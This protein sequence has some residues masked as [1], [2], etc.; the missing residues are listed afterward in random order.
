MAQFIAKKLNISAHEFPRVSFLW[1][2]RFL[3]QFGFIFAWTIITAMFVS[4]FGVDNILY[5]LLID[6]ALLFLGGF[7]IKYLFLKTPTNKFLLGAIAGTMLSLGFGMYFNGYTEVC[8]LSLLIAKDFFFAQLGLG[9]L[10]KNESLLSPTEAQKVMPVIESSITIGTI[11]A[12]ALFLLLLQYFPVG[13]LLFVWLITLGLMFIM[14]ARADKSLGEV[15]HLYQEETCSLEQ[16]QFD[17]MQAQGVPFIKLLTLFIF[18]QGAL[19]SV[20]E[21]QFLKSVDEHTAHETHIEETLPATSLEASMIKDTKHKITEVGVEVKETISHVSNKIFVHKTLAHDLGF[22][23]LVFGLLALVVQLSLTTRILKRWGIIRTI[24]GYFSGFLAIIATFAGGGASMNFVRG[25]QHGF[26]SIL[27]VPYH[28]SFYSMMSH[29]REKVR[30]FLEGFVK[31]IGAMFGITLILGLQPYYSSEVIPYV[32]VGLALA[33]FAVLWPMKA[34]FT[35]LSHRNLTSDQ[36]IGA[37]LHAIEVLAQRGHENSALILAEELLKKDSHP[38]IREKIMA[39]ISRINDPQVVHTYLNILSDKEEDQETK[40]RVLES[41]LR[42]NSLGNY[43]SE[44]AFSQHHLL[45]ILQDLFAQTKH[46]HVQ[47]LVIMNI[48]AHIPAHQVV[49]FFTETIQNADDH[50]KSICLRSVSE[51]FQDPE[52]VYYVQEFLE[53]D[54]PRLQ[55]YAIM[56]LWK[57]KDQDQL[58]T[59]I[60]DLLLQDSAEHKV[61]ALYA[62]G[63]VQD[64]ESSYHLYPYLEDKDSDVRL[65]AAVALAKIED[66]NAVEIIIKMLFEL[67]HAQSK[68][69]F[70]MLRR[71]PA[72]VRDQIRKEVGYRVSQQVVKVLSRE[73]IT[74]KSQ[75]NKLSKSVKNQL[76]HWYRLAEKYDDLLVIEG[77]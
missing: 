10:K 7:L 24:I 57:F 54:N 66:Q 49:P 42:L 18:I 33:A 20:V 46:G 41:L 26:H 6:A 16:H 40:I 39:T 62:L 27:D 12:A 53:A 15:P 77:V 32:M 25:F 63:E 17:V 50:L 58:R 34:E 47:K 55:G 59:K 51:V 31:P 29:R 56:A 21:F 13:E 70:Y 48:F 22:L 8:F 45:N 35:R 4:L 61:A 65:H 1:K 75:F 67:D 64:H 43:W 69:L 14:I 68:K 73:K 76:T 74:H 28:L 5:L 37:K 52:I 71:L 3:F 19:F 44:H 38:V 23:S 60:L 30:H 11:S 2:L 9:I 36:N 72:E